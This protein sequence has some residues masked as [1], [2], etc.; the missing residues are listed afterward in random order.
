MAVELW[1]NIFCEEKR[2]CHVGFQSNTV[3]AGVPHRGKRP[4][5]H[6]AGLVIVKGLLIEQHG[7]SSSSLILEELFS[8]DF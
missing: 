3:K 6:P 1:Q 8:E 2:I 5:G 7:L 4:C